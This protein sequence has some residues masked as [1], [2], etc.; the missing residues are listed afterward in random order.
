[1]LCLKLV[2]IWNRGI[3][4]ARFDGDVFVLRGI[5]VE[6]D[7][8]GGDARLSHIIHFETTSR[9]FFCEIEIRLLFYRPAILTGFG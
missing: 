4:V 2:R 1:M 5:S 6:F 8:F 3:P 9:K 7:D